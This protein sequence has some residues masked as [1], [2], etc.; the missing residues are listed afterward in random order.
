MGLNYV[1]YAFPEPFFSQHG[2]RFANI[3][4]GLWTGMSFGAV[5]DIHRFI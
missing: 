1:D 2:V 3:S 5:D 4:A